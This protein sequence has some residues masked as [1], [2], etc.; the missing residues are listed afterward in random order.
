MS[1]MNVVKFCVILCFS[2]CQDTHCHSPLTFLSQCVFLW[3]QGVL[4]LLLLKSLV[5]PLALQVV[6]LYKIFKGFDP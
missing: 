3:A 6:T 2:F 1:S 5:F 4:K